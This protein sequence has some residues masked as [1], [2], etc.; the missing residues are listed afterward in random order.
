[1]KKLFLAVLLLGCW[2]GG[3]QAQEG[4]TAKFLIDG[5]FFSEA[6]SDLEGQRYSVSILNKEGEGM[7]F[8]ITGITLSEKARTYAIPAAQRCP[9]QIIGCS[10]Q[11][12]QR[13]SCRCRHKVPSNCR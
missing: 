5:L 9:M 11:G 10:R 3:V 13:N 6:P 8:L 2:W 1:M 12:R 7:M 4:R